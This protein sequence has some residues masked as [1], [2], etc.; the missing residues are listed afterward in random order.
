MSKSDYPAMVGGISV[1]LL[2][3]V[4]AV[5][6]VPRGLHGGCSMQRRGC[7]LTQRSIKGPCLDWETNSAL[8]ECKV[9]EQ[10]IEVEVGNISRNQIIKALV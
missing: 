6:K 7:M 1:G 4:E 2:G 9:Q 8:M 3:S 10:V 5:L